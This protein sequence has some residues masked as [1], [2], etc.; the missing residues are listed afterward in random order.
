VGLSKIF[1]LYLLTAS[2]A[3]TLNDMLEVGMKR[4]EATA[5]VPESRVLDLLQIAGLGDV[6]TFYGSSLLRGWVA[7]KM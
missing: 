2:S 1:D 5:I 6:L 4:I 3:Q 7:T